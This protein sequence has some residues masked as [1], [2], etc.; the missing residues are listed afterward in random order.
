MGDGT[1]ITQ[2]IYSNPMEPGFWLF[3]PADIT[4]ALQ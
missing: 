4:V 2:V 1:A 3:T